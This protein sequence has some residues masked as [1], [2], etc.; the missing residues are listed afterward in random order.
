MEQELISSVELNPNFTLNTTGKYILVITCLFLFL[1][2]VAQERFNVRDVADQDAAVFT[3]ILELDDNYIVSGNALNPTDSGVYQSII[4][5]K[6]SLGGDFLEYKAVNRAEGYFIYPSG[7]GI[8]ELNDNFNRTCTGYIHSSEQNNLGFIVNYDEEGDTLNLITF[9]SP[10]WDEDEQTGNAILPGDICSSAN[11]DNSI[12]ISSS[13]LNPELGSTGGDFYIQRMAPDG[14][15]LWEYIYATDAQPEYCKALLPTEDGGVLGILTEIDLGVGISSKFIELDDSG[16]VITLNEIDLIYG[17]NDLA[18][19]DEETFIAVGLG[20]ALDEQPTGIIFKLNL[21]G[22]SLWTNAI[23]EG[24]NLDFQNQFYKVVKS[25]DESGYLAGGTKKEFIPTQEQ[26][27]SSGN[28]ISQ[29]WLVKVN[30]DGEVLWDR[31]YHYI[32]TLNEEHTLND[33]KATSDGGYIFCGESRDL[34]SGQPFSEGPPQQGWLVKVDEYG[35]LVEDCQLSDG[36]NVIEQEDNLEY[37]KAGPIPAADFLNVYQRITAHLATYQLINSQG[38]VVEEF[39]ALSKGSTM[40]LD[41]SK[42]STGSYQLVLREGEEVLQ[43]QKI[44]KL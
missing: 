23:G 4:W 15:V 24:Y 20:E 39:P 40:M 3:G 34:D 30:E 8:Q 14:E 32:N 38:K 33:L 2:G 10:Y 26:T 18:W 28:T 6:F 22:D 1:T 35:C 37:F 19:S 13:I 25:L 5:S 7:I 44:T 11:L 31:T 17:A 43:I 16:E 12:F 42:Y 29:G 9:P 27:D 41:V 21:N 36:I